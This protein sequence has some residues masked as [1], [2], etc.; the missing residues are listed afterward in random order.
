[1]NLDENERGRILP[2]TELFV[3]LATL[4]DF[5]LTIVRQAN[6]VS[7]QGSR[8]WSLVEGRQVGAVD[9]DVTVRVQVGHDRL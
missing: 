4:I 1:M 5:Q 8:C 9:V 6:G 2:L 3:E 7:L